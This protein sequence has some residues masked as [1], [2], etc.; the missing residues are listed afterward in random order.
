MD[1][2]RLLASI[3]TGGIPT[4]VVSGV[5]T[6]ERIERIYAEQGVFAFIEKQTFDRRAF[7]RTLEEART[8]ATTRSELDVLS[9]RE[10]EVVELLAQGMTNKEIAATLYITPNTVKRHLNSVFA[11]LDVHT[12]S[13]AVAKAVEGSVVTRLETGT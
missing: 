6:P 8:T 3:K 5:A 7:L 1:G 13:A 10:R 4:I 9:R 2:S 12:R 11:K